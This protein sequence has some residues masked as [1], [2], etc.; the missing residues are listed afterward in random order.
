MRSGP[1]FLRLPTSGSAMAFR[2]SPDGRACAGSPRRA[3]TTARSTASSPNWMRRPWSGI[4]RDLH[5]TVAKAWNA[6]VR[7]HR[8]A[9][10]RPVAVPPSRLCAHPNPLAAAPGLVPG[11]CRAI[12]HLGVRAGPSRRGSSGK[13]PRTAEPAPAANAH[14]FGRERGGCGRD[15]ARSDYLFGEPCRTRDL[16]RPPAPSL[17]AGRMQAVRLHAWCCRHADRDC[18]G[19]GEGVPRM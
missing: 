18:V 3:S 5:R 2:A 13:G 14:P 8:G 9:G 7:L 6:L 19:M 12:P 17:A 1:G 11:G 16:P 10:L 15:P 4:L